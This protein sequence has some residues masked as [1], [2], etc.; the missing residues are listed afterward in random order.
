MLKSRNIFGIPQELSYFCGTSIHAFFKVK[1]R[2]S[3][4]KS[5]ASKP[6]AAAKPAPP[7]RRKLNGPAWFGWMAG[8][9]L[10][11]IFCTW[12]YGDVFARAQQEAFVSSDAEQ[13]KFLTDKP[14]GRIYWLGRWALLVYKS[15]WVGGLV[16]SLML[17]LSAWLLRSGE[18]GKAKGE[19]S[20]KRWE[21]VELLVP[22]GVLAWL[23][24]KGTRLYYGGEPSLIVLLPLAV[25]L[26]C[27][28]IRIFCGKSKEKLSTVNCQLSTAYGWWLAALAFV[29]LFWPG[30]YAQQN[31]RLAARMQN[32]CLEQNWERMLSDGESARQPTRSVAAYYAIASLRTGRLLDNMFQIP[33]DYPDAGMDIGKERSKLPE[34]QQY[35]YKTAEEYKL[36]QSDCDFAAGLVQPAY[37]YC[38]EYNVMQG[39]T[40]RNLKRMAICSILLGETNLAKKYMDI[41]DHV[42]LEGSFVERYRPM[43]ENA[44]LVDAD[45][46]LAAVKQLMPTTYAD[47]APFLDKYRPYL[48]PLEAS[49]DPDVQVVAQR[50]VPKENILEQS[51]AQ[52]IFL[53]FYAKPLPTKRENVELVM[54]TSLYSKALPAI[55]APVQIMMAEG[56]PVSGTVKQ[57]LACMILQNPQLKDVFQIEPTYQGQL[58]EFRYDLTEARAKD[59]S[60]EGMRKALKKKWL[61]T[62]YYYYFCENNDPTQ[63]GK[64]SG[65]TGVN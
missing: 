1:E 15:K 21:G 12:I 42:P 41:L 18:R 62:Y 47:D 58:E 28:L 11:W 13:M 53:G 2:K 9:L 37:H 24:S 60:R 27:V 61:G 35:P 6:T 7:A 46:E 30:G 16:L 49:S 48:F 3:K 17:W 32:D 26:I 59:P 56:I 44:A 45:A 50:M 4:V 57:A 33:Y 39:P 36:F 22:I 55:T 25:L 54:A 23:A 52:P 14:F 51:Y 19:K 65:S 40:T 43:I 31:V 5:A 8:W 64:T 10:L 63:T 38:L 29:L 20:S 34:E